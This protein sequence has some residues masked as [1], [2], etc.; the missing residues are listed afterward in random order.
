MGDDVVPLMDERRARPSRARLNQRREEATRFYYYF[1]DNASLFAA[2][3]GIMTLAGVV[4]CLIVWR[5]LVLTDAERA[6]AIDRIHCPNGG[7]PPPPTSPTT[8]STPPDANA[9]TSSSS[10]SATS[11]VWSHATGCA[12]GYERT[13][14]DTTCDV[15]IVGAGAGGLYTALRLVKEGRVADASSI[16]IVDERSVAG[17]RHQADTFTAADGTVVSLPST[18]G[19][20]QWMAHHVELR[21]MLA[22]YGIPAE[23]RGTWTRRAQH[24]EVIDRRGIN[25]TAVTRDGCPEC[26]SF[27]VERQLAPNSPASNYNNEDEPLPAVCTRAADSESSMGTAIG[28]ETTATPSV[29]MENRDYTEC[30][31]ADRMYQTLVANDAAAD[32][33]QS[34]VFHDYMV[35][36]LKTDKRQESPIFH[37]LTTT[38]GIGESIALSQAAAAAAYLRED[39]QRPSQSFIWPTDGGVAALWKRV[40]ETLRAAGVRFLLDERVKCLDRADAGG[41]V[42]RTSAGRNVHA[43]QRLA[44]A[45]SPGVFRRHVRGTLGGAL[46]AE[47]AMSAVNGGIECAINVAFDTPWWQETAHGRRTATENYC[48]D[49]DC[50]DFGAGT[51]PAN[52]TEWTFY[53]R[54]RGWWIRHVPQTDMRRGNV[55]RIIPD[56]CVVPVALFEVR[57]Q[58]EFDAYVKRY[59]HETFGAS[60]PPAPRHIGFFYNDFTRPI[61]HVDASRTPAQVAAFARRPLGGDDASLCFTSGAFQWGRET[62]TNYASIVGA[63]RACF[64]DTASAFTQCQAATGN[65]TL[66]EAATGVTS[67]ACVRL[68]N[69]RPMLAGELPDYCPQGVDTPS[70]ADPGLRPRRYPL[71][72]GQA[73]T[74]RV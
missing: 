74:G 70:A 53:D 68:P 41:Y 51:R 1:N 37:Y 46:G 6:T 21:C 67:N 27:S 13:P 66:A 69:E 71:E 24:W 26:A 14:N 32:A 23:V 40:T 8:N 12:T 58:A 2:L 9:T 42:L 43:R 25:V 3:C 33:Q 19:D 15:V 22:H 20:E 60:G 18:T 50:F 64:D 54:A 36:R 49:A 38:S 44:V 65:V 45:V 56:N 28:N 59:L 5:Q 47:E 35:D 4:A 7:C 55:L 39:W 72:Y 34:V 17:G 29:A 52:A 11:N 30:S 16:C 61:F 57:G 10:S 62:G 63:R 73:N 31:Y 48:Q